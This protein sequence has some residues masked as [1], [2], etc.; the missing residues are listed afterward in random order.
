M[1]QNFEIYTVNM[2]CAHLWFIYLSYYVY[3]RPVK[4]IFNLRVGKLSATKA[5]VMCGR[6]QLGKYVTHILCYRVIMYE[7][8]NEELTTELNI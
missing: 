7:C 1:W 2:C 8:I 3:M 4:F 6:H 5:V